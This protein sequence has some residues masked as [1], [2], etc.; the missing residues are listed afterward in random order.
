[1]P[2]K[3]EVLLPEEVRNYLN[4]HKI[5]EVVAAALSGLV[6]RMP[7][8]PI[9]HVASEIAVAA[10]D[11]QAPPRLAELRPDCGAAAPE[12]LRFDV[13]IL[14]GGIRAAVGSVQFAGNL[15]E[16]PPPP[17][18]DAAADA[19]EDE[20]AAAATPSAAERARARRRLSD[21]LLEFFQKHFAGASVYDL[22]GLH[23]VDAPAGQSDNI[24]DFHQRC[25]ELAGAPLL[26][27]A[28]P[29]D[30]RR[31]TAVLVGALLDACARAVDATCL[32]LLQRLLLRAAGVFERAGREVNLA[33]PPLRSSR[34]FKVWRP[35]WPGLAMPLFL[36]GGPSCIRPASLRICAAFTPFSAGAATSVD[37]EAPEDC[38]VPGWCKTVARMA[39]GAAE[40]AAKA[41]QAD[42]AAA[43]MV[44][45]GLSYC[46]P[47]GLQQTL[48]MAR[49]AA[50]AA[51]PGA[52][53]EV[54]GVLVAA[55]EEAWVDAD[56][57]YELEV[58][59]P[60]S[61]EGLVEFYAQL[62]AEPWI[63]M[64][65]RPFKSSDMAAGCEM[66]HAQFPD[67]RLVADASPDQDAPVPP[68]PA[69]SGHGARYSCAMNLEGSAALALN[70]YA[71]VAPTWCTADGFGRLVHLDAETARCVPAAL[72]VVMACASP[73]VV[74]LTP[75]VTEEDL[76][77]A[78]A[79]IDEL[80]Y[81]ALANDDAASGGDGDDAVVEGVEGSSAGA[82][83]S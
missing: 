32:E 22:A 23:S 60:L 41:L 24:P 45:D 15:Y 9:G 80:L 35:L 34:D 53:S 1:M 73:E 83:E 27:D 65:I 28:C 38:P 72:E 76:A 68:P 42:K 43:A 56:G 59:K 69:R 36:G 17:A 12:D 2:L 14:V 40:N 18:E 54:F 26:D 62:L 52:A 31:A 51:A 79:R 5:D 70:R 61:L 44:V 11:A 47:G 21:F 10:A 81:S 39:R 49:Q 25:A 82:A 33:S 19:A 63:R 29:V 78:S 16:P 37:P 66:L 3:N 7:V 75:D 4:E 13:V 8:D 48:T 74:C 20:A 46:H 6:S 50:E 58:G 71:E 57:M 67:V 77:G 30:V 64:I 55:A